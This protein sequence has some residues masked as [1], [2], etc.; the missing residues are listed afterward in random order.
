MAHIALRTKDS[1]NGPDS[2]NGSIGGQVQE[3]S[4]EPSHTD[5][6]S[7]DPID[8]D[9]HATSPSQFN[10]L[11]DDGNGNSKKIRDTNEDWEPSKHWETVSD[12]ATDVARAAK[13]ALFSKRKNFKKVVAVIAY[14][15]TSTGLEHLRDQADKLGRLFK[16][17]FKFEVLLYKIPENVSNWEFIQTI[18]NE[19]N[20]VI[21]DPDSLFILYYG[22]YA[23]IVNNPRVG[24]RLWEKDDD[25]WSSSKINWSNA[26]TIL[27]EGPIVCNK[28]F[29]FDCCHAGGMIGST[30][31]WK[32]SCELL[33][34][35][36]ADI[37]ASALRVSSFT[38]AILEELSKNTYDIW[39]LHSVL[40]STDK[41]TEYDL[42]Q[43][44]HY[45]NFM[46]RRS[47]SGSTLMKKVRSPV[48]T[49]DRPRRP[50]DILT[51]LRTMSDAEVCVA[52]NF[53]CT[54]DALMEEIK[55]IERYWRRQLKFPPTECD[56]VIA[57]ACSDTKLLAAYDGDSCITIW[58]F[59]VWLWDAM[60]PLSSYKCIG[61]IGPQ[62]F[63]H[64]V[65]GSVTDPA[66]TECSSSITVRE[67]SVS[68]QPKEPSKFPPIQT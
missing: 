28:L 2:I 48:E 51:R 15:K 13:N 39:E 36:A 30:L 10:V 23:S 67:V 41:R 3:I 34:A 25:T 20:K 47:Q 24:L 19:L 33:G 12:L 26:V 29:I 58:T 45:H 62:N 60:A 8:P 21:D 42:S 65:S 61:I 14:W 37:E 32:T 68:R 1:A 55:G 22:G 63:A 31:E 35:C 6:K 52:L 56:H 17:R 4:H 50:S 49:E 7:L 40:C 18:A 64:A 66:P 27:F 54:A 53:D 59:P 16:D 57:R 44:P 38:A 46:G 5:S 43:A 9:V 11:V